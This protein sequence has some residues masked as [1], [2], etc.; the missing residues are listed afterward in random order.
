VS[1]PLAIVP[2]IVEDA[3]QRQQAGVVP[4]ASRGRARPG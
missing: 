2:T 4:T 3:D 1:Q